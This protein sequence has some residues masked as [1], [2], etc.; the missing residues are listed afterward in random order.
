MADSLFKVE[1]PKGNVLLHAKD[2][3]QAVEKALAYLR[4]RMTAQQ[5]LADE[6]GSETNAPIS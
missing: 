4:Q 1:W 2:R 6:P 3:E 5:I